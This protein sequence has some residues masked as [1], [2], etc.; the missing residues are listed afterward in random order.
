M[1]MIISSNDFLLKGQL[2]IRDDRSGRYYRLDEPSGFYTKAA[3]EGSLIKK[4]ISQAYY[5]KCLEDCKAIIA[6]EDALG[7]TA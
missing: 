5:N 3:R 6:A 7:R 1:N 2:Y 4:R